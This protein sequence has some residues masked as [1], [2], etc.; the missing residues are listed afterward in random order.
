MYTLSPPPPDAA[1]PGYLR[2][3]LSHFLV[4]ARDALDDGGSWAA[5]T[6][7]G[8][9]YNGWLWSGLARYRAFHHLSS[10]EG[11][12][13]TLAP[14]VANSGIRVVKGPITIRVL[15]SLSDGPPPPGHSKARQEFYQQ[16][17]GLELDGLRTRSEATNLILD[18]NI[19]RSNYKLTMA[20]SLPL[21][22]W[23]Y[24][25][26]PRTAWRNYVTFTDDDQPRFTATD[27]P[28]EWDQDE[29]EAK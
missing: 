4:S 21:D 3:Y 13:W 20:L 2:Q 26:H 5:T 23:I 8:Q 19:N 27:E 28:L 25:S 17:L 7:H 6:L 29:E 15:K 10:V 9:P 11:R 14:G 16:E 1:D 24:G 12:D 18:W 22:T